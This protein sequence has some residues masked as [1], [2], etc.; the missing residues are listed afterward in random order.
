MFAGLRRYLA[1]WRAYRADPL[2]RE[3]GKLPWIRVPGDALERARA[4]HAAPIEFRCELAG[5]MRALG[6]DTRALRLWG[7]P[8]EWG[9]GWPDECIEQAEP[10]PPPSVDG[11]G[12]PPVY[13]FRPPPVL[14]P[15]PNQ[16][17]ARGVRDA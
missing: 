8:Y 1:T 10:S 12:A 4:L 6:L 9:R 7:D 17:W 15:A 14:Y 3:L 2:A 13:Q 16:G 5:E 11:D